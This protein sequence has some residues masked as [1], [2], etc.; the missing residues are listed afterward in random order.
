MDKDKFIEQVAKEA[1]KRLCTRLNHIRPNQWE[2]L[3]EYQRQRVREDVLMLFDIT[4]YFEIVEALKRI[5]DDLPQNR[6]WLDPMVE[7]IAKEAL[8]KAG[9][10]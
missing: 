9:V 5:I 8:R 7:R 2:N 1:H 4:G 6:D 10:L 3:E